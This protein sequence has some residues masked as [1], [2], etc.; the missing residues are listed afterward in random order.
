MTLRLQRGWPC[1]SNRRLPPAPHISWG[2]EGGGA[3]ALSFP[4]H[5]RL[6]AVDPRG[7]SLPWDK[8]EKPG[9]IVFALPCLEGDCCDVWLI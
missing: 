6:R 5:C 8:R 4:G 2:L 7:L 9:V 1:F 3:A